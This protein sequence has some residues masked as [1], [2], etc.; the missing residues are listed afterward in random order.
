LANLSAGLK[1]MAELDAYRPL[2]VSS[3]YMTAPVGPQDQ[4]S[5]VNAVACG[6]F[7]GK[8]AELLEGLLAIEREQGRIRGRRWGPRILDL[9]ILLFGRQIIDQPGLTVPHPEIARRAFVLV[10]LMEIAPEL[11]LP[12]WNRTAVQLWAELEPSQKFQQKIEKISWD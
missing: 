3:P 2:Q 5:F 6:I 1:Q 8:A 4:P 9:D 10:P 7:G 12:N 11:V